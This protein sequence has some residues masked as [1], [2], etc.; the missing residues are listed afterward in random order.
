VPAKTEVRP[1]GDLARVGHQLAIGEW[2][3]RHSTRR[4]GFATRINL[5]TTRSR[6]RARF[7]TNGLGSGRLGI[8][9]H[10]FILPIARETLSY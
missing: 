10:G 2:R 9:D 7:E 5:H 8:A 6:I 4:G 1:A 3:L